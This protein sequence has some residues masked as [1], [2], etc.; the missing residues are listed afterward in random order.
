MKKFVLGLIVA[1][2]SFSA[3]LASAADIAILNSSNYT[4]EFFQRRY[5]QDG[6]CSVGTYLGRNEYERYYRGWK[7][8][9]DGQQNNSLIPGL[10]ASSAPYAYDILTDADLSA[11]LD[12]L[13]PSVEIWAGGPAASRHADRLQ[14]R[15]LVLGDFSMYLQQLDRVAQVGQ[16]LS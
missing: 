10:V 16:R 4:A 8:V 3:T 5:G 15:A 1:L 14:P 6:A 9:L 12:G 7:Y 11:M 2:A 13:S